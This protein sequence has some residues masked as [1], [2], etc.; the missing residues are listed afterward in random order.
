MMLLKG[1]AWLGSMAGYVGF[2]AEAGPRWAASLTA[3]CSVSLIL[4][5][6][7]LAGLLQPC[8]WL[9]LVCGLCLLI[10]LLLQKKM[11][12]LFPEFCLMAAAGALLWLRYRS[13]LLVAYDD[14]SHWGMIVQRMLTTHAF[15]VAEDSLIV[16][17]SYPPGA[18]CWLYDAGLF[19]GNGDGLLLTA[20]GWLPQ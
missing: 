7:G 12:R 1:M 2:F 13:A 17:Q 5:A 20:Q 16:F 18:A 19:W 9:L 15:P 11:G 8:A 4:Y 6:A 10:R 14:F 3:A